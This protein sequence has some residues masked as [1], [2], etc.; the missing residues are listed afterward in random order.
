MR[1]TREVSPGTAGRRDR[2][3]L[4]A[5]L[6][7]F[8]LLA[9]GVQPDHVVARAERA[10]VRAP[11]PPIGLW[12]AVTRI[13]EGP[14]LVGATVAAAALAHGDRRHAAFLVA[15]VAV[16]VAAR[17]V[18]AE[19]IRRARPPRAWWWV[20]PRGFSFPSRHVTWFCLGAAALVDAVPDRARPVGQIASWAG[21]AMVGASRIRLGIHWPSDVAGAAFA[22]AAVR[23]AGRLAECR[24]ARPPVITGI[25]GSLAREL[26]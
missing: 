15:R 8:V 24:S 5:S 23:A 7:A 9:I 21:T 10:G 14:A 12:P 6:T 17:R 19:V 20:T 13:G 3:I 11:E 1:A 18:L 16:G 22:A 26:T 2:A 4:A 25:T